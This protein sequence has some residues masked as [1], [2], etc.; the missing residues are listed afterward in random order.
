MGL[1]QIIHTPTPP[2]PYPCSPN[3][4]SKHPGP[5]HPSGAHPSAQL[6]QPWDLRGL[7]GTQVPHRRVPT[8]MRG[9]VPRQLAKNHPGTPQG[10]A[11]DTKNQPPHYK[12][13][14][15]GR[16][17][18][19]ECQQTQTGDAAVTSSPATQHQEIYEATKTHH[20]G[21][22]RPVPPSQLPGVGQ[23]QLS[24][25]R[26]SQPSPAHPGGA[27]PRQALGIEARDLLLLNPTDQ[28]SQHGLSPQP[29]S[30]PHQPH[31]PTFCLALPQFPSSATQSSDRGVHE[32][33][34]PVRSASP[35]P[36]PTKRDAHH[37]LSTQQNW[38]GASRA[39]P[40]G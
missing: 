2:S 9:S 19:S 23:P 3:L 11:A 5:E 17:E 39:H 8:T 15:E 37:V 40:T 6:L 4:P 38:G 14:A 32:V 21:V 25:P 27:S 22:P 20:G 1:F 7:E 31:D 24:A 34:I 18:H 10:A 30:Q 13:R 36:C 29:Y 35:W 12:S 16:D 28:Q 26:G 33:T